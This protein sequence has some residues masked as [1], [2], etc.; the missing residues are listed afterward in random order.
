MIRTLLS[1]VLLAFATPVAA[2]GDLDRGREI[3]ETHCSRC[4]QVGAEGESPLPLAPPFRQLGASYPL[5]D[6][7]EALAEGIVTGHPEMPEFQFAPSDVVALIAYLESIQ[8]D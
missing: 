5:S 8:Q 7:E 3:A 4:H 2:Q 6:L 1:A